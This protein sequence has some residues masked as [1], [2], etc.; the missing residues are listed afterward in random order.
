M[1]DTIQMGLGMARIEFVDA[2]TVAA[3]N[4]YK[5]ADL[6][7]CP[8]L[9]V[10]FHGSE[11][12]V[13]EQAETFGE[14]AARPRR[15]GGFDWAERPEDR[16]ALWTMRH[17]AYWAILASRPGAR[18]MVTDICVPISRLAEAVEATRADIAAS[19]IDGPILGHVG[20]G[21]FHAIL[22]F[23]DTDPAQAT[24]AKDLAARMVE[25]ALEM[26]GTATGEHGIGI[27]KLD[28]MQAEHGAAWSVMGALKSALDPSGIMNPGKMVPARPNAIE[29]GSLPAK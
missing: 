3:F 11:A 26:G 4:A 6:P 12:G 7:E 16:S 17:H 18:A 1:I 14:I 21:N 8:H 25:R 22:L 9:M 24:A 29:A 5:G 23:D 10:E 20:D 2:E 19:P 15:Q 27:G 28:Y 13:A